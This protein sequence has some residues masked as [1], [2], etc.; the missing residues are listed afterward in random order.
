MTTQIHKFPDIVDPHVNDLLFSKN[1]E[2]RSLKKKVIKSYNKIFE[3]EYTI[4]GSLMFANVVKELMYY[5]DNNKNKDLNTFALKSSIIYNEHEL[6][7]KLNKIYTTN[8]FN[9]VDIE[10]FFGK[11][12]I[13][14]EY[15]RPSTF[16][17]KRSV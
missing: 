16:L 1:R 2:I 13:S 3:I 8:K 4:K 7:F 12:G 9:Y 15:K 14:I 17:F 5:I 10:M 6:W 11:V